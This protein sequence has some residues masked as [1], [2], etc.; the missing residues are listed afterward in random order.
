M[1]RP[2]GAVWHSESYP[3]GGVAGGAMAGFAALNGTLGHLF[4]FPLPVFGGGFFFFGLLL[5][6]SSDLHGL[7]DVADKEAQ[8]VIAQRGLGNAARILVQTFKE[9]FGTRPR[10][11][12]LRDPED[13]ALDWLL[14]EAEVASSEGWLGFWDAALRGVG[15]KACG[16][17]ALSLLCGGEGGGRRVAERYFEALRGVVR[18][19]SL[20]LGTEPKPSRSLH[21]WA[22]TTLE[23]LGRGVEAAFL[24]DLRVARLVADYY[25]LENPNK[26]LA[27]EEAV[28]KIAQRLQGL[29]LEEQG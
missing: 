9:H 22:K 2:A 1:F 27:C 20:V 21:F 8:A 12:Y 28:D 29:T 17:F 24:D 26:R 14:L 15:V 19:L 3:S 18:W 25:L 5:G 11:R 13:A 16:Y 23:A 4:P 7:D 6:A 10:L